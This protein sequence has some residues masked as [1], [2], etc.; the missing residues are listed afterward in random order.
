V[1]LGKPYTFLE[2]GIELAKGINDVEGRGTR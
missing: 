2:I 1:E